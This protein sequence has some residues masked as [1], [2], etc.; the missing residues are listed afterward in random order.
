MITR[1]LRYGIIMVYLIGAP[2]EAQTLIRESYL[3]ARNVALG[4]ANIADAHDMSAIYENPSSIAFLEEPSV[5]FNH[6]QGNFSEMQ[7]N[8]AFPVVYS[9]SQML[10]LGAQFYTIGVFTNSRVTGR[11]ATGYDIA[12]AQRL[13]QAFGLGGAVTYQTGVVTHGSHASAASYSLGVE[14]APTENVKYGLVLSDLGTNLDFIDSNSSVIPVQTI[15]PR[16]LEVGA[17]MRFPSDETM[18]PSFL[19]ISLASEKIFGVSGVNYRGGIEYYPFHFLALRFGYVA[20]PSIHEPRYG[21][22][23][24]EGPFS[25]DYAAYTLN[26]GGKG[27]LFEQLSASMEF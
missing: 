18:Q 20:G 1:W 15:T 8:L 21:V 17:T 12:Y 27:I 16:R 9:S 6:T 4:N 5:F 19:N 26:D 11:Y 14:Y 2:L 23:L 10:A 22:G 24:K 25:V 7:E 3:G 13:T